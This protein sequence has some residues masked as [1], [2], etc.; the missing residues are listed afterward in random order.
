MENEEVFTTDDILSDMGIQTPGAEDKTQDDAPQESEDTE[1]S[2]AGDESETEEE[3]PD[4]KDEP[5]DGDEYD[6][7]TDPK[8]LRERLRSKDKGYQQQ[9]PY[10]KAGKLVLEAMDENNPKRG[11][12]AKALTEIVG[13]GNVQQTT[14]TVNDWQMPEFEDPDDAE[15]VTAHF[16]NVIQPYVAHVT[17]KLTDQIGTLTKQVEE[18]TGRLA[19]PLS[20]YEKTREQ[21]AFEQS[22]EE[23]SKQ[24]L[25]LYK[26]KTGK[27]ASKDDLKAA[28]TTYRKSIET[29]ELKPVDAL[30]LHT[31]KAAAKPPAKGKDGLPKMPKTTSNERRPDFT[32][33]RSVNDIVNDL[34]DAAGKP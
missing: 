9:D 34:F 10:I 19:E 5:S 29:G 4:D 26:A 13:L 24:T 33:A 7:I 16:E 30:I 28:M 18:L 22:V 8:I 6:K 32:G 14:A 2:P 1:G 12:A 17:Q 3:A 15:S 20:Q 27:D 11:E 21:R 31:T 25:G 23:A